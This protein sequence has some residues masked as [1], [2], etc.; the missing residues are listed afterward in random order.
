MS[1][2]SALTFT[3]AR[4]G[5]KVDDP[6][7]PGGRTNLGIT[8]RVWADWRESYDP[9]LPVDVWD[10]TGEQVGPLY[11]SVYWRGAG[12]D[13]L[14][15][16]PALALFD[17]AVNLGVNEALALWHRVN[18]D[19]NAFL[20]ARLGFYTDLARSKPELVKFL[21]GWCRRVLLLRDAT[22]KVSTSSSEV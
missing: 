19:V 12:C 22:L 2:Q 16:G 7:D 15:E 3:L 13:H 18:G 11:E 8:Q 21:P 1:F 9:D 20:W 5:G 6:S 10:A 14:P 17:S 4:E